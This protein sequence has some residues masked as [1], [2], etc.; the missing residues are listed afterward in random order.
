MQVEPKKKGQIPLTYPKVWVHTNQVKHISK[1]TNLVPKDNLIPIPVTLQK[2]VFLFFLKR[3]FSLP[4]PTLFVPT[5]SISLRPPY[6]LIPLSP[7][8]SFFMTH[9]FIVSFF[10]QATTVVCFQVTTMVGL[11]WFLSFLSGFYVQQWWWVPILGRFAMEWFQVPMLWVFWIWVLL[12]NLG[13]VAMGLA[14]VYGRW[15]WVSIQGGF[16]MGVVVGL[17]R[18]KLGCQLVVAIVAQVREIGMA[19]ERKEGERHRWR[20]SQ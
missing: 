11:L 20:E 14:R 6:S 2:I 18:G 16:A 8:R 19:K 15:W 3:L 10:S 4:L 9:P 13:S 17:L 12:E 1:L 5:L 7:S